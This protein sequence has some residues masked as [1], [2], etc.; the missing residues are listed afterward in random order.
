[1]TDANLEETTAEALEQWRDSEQ[2]AVNRSQWQVG[3]RGGS[4]CGRGR[5]DRR[6]S[7]S[8]SRQGGAQV[9]QVG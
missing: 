8:R 5:G 1:M 3:G 2:T 7:N 4:G 6:D 9:V